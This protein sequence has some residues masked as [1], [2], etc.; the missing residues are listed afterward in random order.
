MSLQLSQGIKRYRIP[1]HRHST[2]LKIVTKR[3][4]RS[5]KPVLETFTETPPDGGGPPPVMLPFDMEKQ[6]MSFWCWAASAKSISKFY[7]V[8]SGWTQCGVAATTLNNT[9]CCQAPAPCNKQWYL[10]EALQTTGNFIR[11]SHPLSF[12]EVKRELSADRVVACR[13]GWSDGSGHFVVIHGCRSDDGVNY[14][15]IDDPN[16]G[17]SEATENGFRIA[18]LGNGKWTHSFITKP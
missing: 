11:Y 15:S 8:H 3:L 4:V 16:S 12:D 9:G 14:F 6:S 10:H 2:V 13:V 18:Y 17:K 1:E 5:L 7:D